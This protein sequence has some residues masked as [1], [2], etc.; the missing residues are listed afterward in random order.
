MPLDALHILFPILA[1]IL[2]LV[3]G[4]F[5]N[6]CIHRYLTGESIVYPG[7]HCP[8]CA[9]PLA[10]WENIP[11]LS[12]LLLWGRCRSCREKISWRYPVVEGLSG[13]WALGLALVYGPGWPFVV[14][15][16]FGGLL[17]VASFIDLELFILPDVLILPGCVAAPLCAVYLLHMDWQVSLIGGVA[18]G[19]TFL[20]LQL[21]YRLLRGV[22]GLGTGDVK[23]MFLLG[24]LLG[25]PALPLMILLSSVAGLLVSIVYLKK[26]STQGMKTAI[27]FGPFL[28]LGA[29]IYVL[30][31]EWLWL[32]LLA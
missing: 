5:Y 3:L 7:S 12:Y 13:V 1:L 9:H 11:L 27:P 15:L 30:A 18:G 6:V 22:E 4:S 26:D 20:L 19:G 21:V 2:G 16:A 24:C 28:T 31:G 29:G 14:F 25:W 8:E 32:L 23:L 10:W 17:L